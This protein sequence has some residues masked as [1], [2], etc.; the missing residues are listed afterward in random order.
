M[1]NTVYQYIKRTGSTTTEG[2]TSKKVASFCK[3]CA[4]SIAILNEHNFSK[5]EYIPIATTIFNRCIVLLHQTEDKECHQ[6]LSSAIANLYRNSRYKKQIT[7]A[8]PDLQK[9]LTSNDPEALC[10]VLLAPP[11]KIIRFRLFGRFTLFWC[12]EDPQKGVR[13]TLFGKTLLTVGS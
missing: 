13:I 5:K 2:L 7:K 4:Q 3:Y 6:L 8:R 1:D 10:N 11:K 9:H 12:E